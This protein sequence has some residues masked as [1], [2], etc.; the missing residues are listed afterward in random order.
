[1]KK[2]GHSYVGMINEGATKTS[3]IK[4]YLG[5]STQRTP[6]ITD[7]DWIDAYNNL[8]FNC[9][10]GFDIYNYEWQDK[11]AKMNVYNNWARKGPSMS[12]ATPYR[13]GRGRVYS[14]GAMV[15]F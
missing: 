13:A 5:D 12:N 1:M 15:C 9:G 8:L 11:N 7:A 4:N 10:N 14:G 6:R 3:F 2:G